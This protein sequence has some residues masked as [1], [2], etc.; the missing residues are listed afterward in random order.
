MI[1]AVSLFSGGLDSLLAT[2]IILNQGVEVIAVNFITPFDHSKKMVEKQNFARTISLQ[3]EIELIE[4]ALR[5][6]FLEILKNPKHGYGKNLN[7]CID[8]KILMLK[9]AHKVMMKKNASFIVTGEVL[10]QR[11]KSQFLWGLSII[12][13]DSGLKGLILRPLSAKLLLETLPEKEGWVNRSE[14]YDFSGRIRG[15]QFALAQQMGINE[16]PAPAGGCLLTDPL[17]ARRVN[18]LLTHDALTMEN[19][20]LL[21]L[22]RYFRLNSQFNLIVGRNQR[23][24]LALLDGVNPGD[25]IFTPFHGKGPTGIGKGTI[26]GK[27]EQLSA[28]I[29]AFYSSSPIEP[30]LINLQRYGYPSSKIIGPLSLSPEALEQYRVENFPIKPNGQG[31][32]ENVGKGE[33]DS[34]IKIQKWYHNGQGGF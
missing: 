23:D 19:A 28:D 22:G 11:P 15:P 29:I 27:S 18:D 7:P 34:S 16:Y 1:K 12:D 17:F 10:S 32:R 20:E 4:I 5:E 8:C 6:D 25:Y 30:L 31:L 13:R 33:F 2:K 14:L 9:E 26:D 21:K 3:M 24:N